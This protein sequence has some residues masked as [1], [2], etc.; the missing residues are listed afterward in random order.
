MNEYVPIGEMFDFRADDCKSMTKVF[1]ASESRGG[2]PA[3]MAPEI[4]VTPDKKV[5]LNY[6]KADIWS[7]G[8][9]LAT[10]MTTNAFLTSHNDSVMDGK[11]QLRR[12][13]LIASSTSVTPSPVAR[14]RATTSI[15]TMTD[16][17]RELVIQSLVLAPSERWSCSQVQSFISL[18]IACT[19][20]P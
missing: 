1:S 19:C 15:A 20:S 13:A 8:V 6:E 18:L 9:I 2:A 3:A 11:K 7:L 12:D 16:I 17:C 5:E 10:M 14:S 4:V